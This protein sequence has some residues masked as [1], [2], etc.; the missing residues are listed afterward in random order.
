MRTRLIAC[1]IILMPYTAR[2]SAQTNDDVAAL[3]EAA[4]RQGVEHRSQLLAARKHF[5]RATDLYRDLHRRGV[6]STA[7]YLNLGN[8]AVLADRWPVAIW[9]YHLG[10]KLD[11]NDRTLREHL[12]FVRAK[13][14]Y[15]PAGQGR[16]EP[17]P[18][19]AWLHRPTTNEWILLFLASWLLFWVIAATGLALRSWKTLLAAV[20]AS[21]LPMAAGI[22]MQDNR[23]QQDRDMPLVIV[24]DNSPFYRGNGTS[25]LQHPILPTLPRGLEVRQLHCRGDWLQVRLT[26]GEVG[27]LPLQNVLVVEP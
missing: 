21:I 3:A 15:P 1:M 19:P 5:S 7:L 11:P 10:L 16:L 20:G 2:V 26:T 25:Y 13:V 8:A 22:Y 9:A 12:A 14:I 18:W 4:F 17:D 27:W 6:R 24:A 23:E